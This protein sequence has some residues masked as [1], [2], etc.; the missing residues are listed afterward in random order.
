MRY[1]GTFGSFRKYSIPLPFKIFIFYFFLIYNITPSDRYDITIFRMNV[2]MIRPFKLMA[3]LKKKKKILF[4]FF[5]IINAIDRALH[6]MMMCCVKKIARSIRYNVSQRMVSYVEVAI[7]S[8][9]S[10]QFNIGR[11]LVLSIPYNS[12]PLKTYFNNFFRTFFTD[13][14]KIFFISFFKI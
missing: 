6:I 4:P 13:N 14:S 7:Q 5:P 8:R 11:R 12:S 9:Q 1:D 2:L 10:T 3:K